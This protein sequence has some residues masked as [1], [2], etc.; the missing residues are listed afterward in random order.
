MILQ[1]EKE[2]MISIAMNSGPAYIMVSG[3][4]DSA[5]EYFCDLLDSLVER[6]YLTGKREEGYQLTR[7]GQKTVTRLMLDDEMRTKTAS[8]QLSRLGKEC[9]DRLEKLKLAS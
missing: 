8:M 4:T 1:H 3:S 6:G 9:I 5:S 2:I 7:L